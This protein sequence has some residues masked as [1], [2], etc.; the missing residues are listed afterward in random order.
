MRVLISVFGVVLLAAAPAWAQERD[1]VAALFDQNGA[2]L[3]D[4]DAPEA[5]EAAESAAEAYDER[6]RASF[7]A[8]QSFQGPLDGGWTL[9][10][11]NE[12]AI[13]ALRFVDRKD[14]LEAVWRD[15]RRNS[16]L[17]ASG[18]VDAVERMGGKLT[19]RFSPAAGAQALLMLHRASDGSWVGELRENGRNRD[20]WLTKTFP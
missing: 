18:L 16:A 1:P 19:L 9:I 7:A 2:D 4:T 15:L 8:A 5:L 10:A 3:M 20:V 14:K 12:G 13:F 6:L 11:Q 17:D